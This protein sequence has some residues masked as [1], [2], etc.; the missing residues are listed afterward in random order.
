MATREVVVYTTMFCPYCQRAKALL[1]RKGVAFKE[2]AVDGD[3]EARKTM[4]A[5]ASGA[6][7]VPQIFIGDQH[8]GGSDELYALEADGRLDGLLHELAD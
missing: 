8:V 6:R 7:T 2:V 3:P 4:V 5:K 1:A